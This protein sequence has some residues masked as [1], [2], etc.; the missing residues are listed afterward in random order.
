MSIQRNFLTT[1]ALLFAAGFSADAQDTV[2]V[3]QDAALKAATAKYEPDY[4]PMAKQL[5]LEGTVQLEAHIGETGAVEGVKPVTGN[6]V[7][8]NAAVAA[9]KRWKFTPF[10]ADGKPVKAVADMTFRFKL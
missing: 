10:T 1:A 7:L 4:P 8:M 5:H 3:T 9:V 2:H 6:A